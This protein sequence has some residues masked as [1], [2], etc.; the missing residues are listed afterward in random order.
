MKLRKLLLHL[1][2]ML[3][4]ACSSFVPQSRLP[5]PAKQP[6]N[7]TMPTA[8]LKHST[9]YQQTTPTVDNL[10][11]VAPIK[12]TL[13]AKYACVCKSQQHLGR[14][15]HVV[16]LNPFTQRGVLFLLFIRH[17]CRQVGLY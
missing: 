10:S 4:T 11:N 8:P 16:D 13:S 5:R 9:A 6:T 17:L 14:K 1:P 12:Y 2:V 3:L 7:E 15:V